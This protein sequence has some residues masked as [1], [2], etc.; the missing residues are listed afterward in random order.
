MIVGD[1]VINED[2]DNNE[3]VEIDKLKLSHLNE[4]TQ[5]KNN[6]NNNINDFKQL[7][8]NEQL[9]L[10]LKEMNVTRPSSIQVKAIPIGLT[11]CDLIAMSKNGTGKT[12]SFGI[13]NLMFFVFS[14]FLFY[15]FSFLL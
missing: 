13:K 10:G 15:F 4:I 9:I 8:I 7:G 12:I 3:I 2:N 5:D 11:K 6:N 14:F 1:V